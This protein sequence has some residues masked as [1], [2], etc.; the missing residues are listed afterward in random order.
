MDKLIASSRLRIVRAFSPGVNSTVEQEICKEF[1]TVKLGDSKSLLRRDSTLLRLAR[2]KITH[3]L[4]PTLAT[5]SCFRVRSFRACEKYK[6]SAAPI[7]ASLD[8]PL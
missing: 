8:S 2:T 4:T 5:Q 7:F 6:I 1:S 3:S